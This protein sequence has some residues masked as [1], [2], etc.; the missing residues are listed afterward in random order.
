MPVRV[1]EEMAFGVIHGKVPCSSATSRSGRIPARKRLPGDVSFHD[2]G[3]SPRRASGHERPDLYASRAT[4]SRSC[5]R[6]ARGGSTSRSG[7]TTSRPPPRGAKT[8]AVRARPFTVYHELAAAY[9]LG[10]FGLRRPAP[11]SRSAG[12]ALK[13]GKWNEQGLPFYS[14]VGRVPAGFE[15]R[16]PRDVTPCGCRPGTAAWRRTS[17]TTARRATRLCPLA[18]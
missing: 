9:V 2:R 10:D 11:A 1:S 4:E 16:G 8:A 5:P 12:L 13:L 17:S 3:R 7:G 18:M 6:R 15:C 14:A